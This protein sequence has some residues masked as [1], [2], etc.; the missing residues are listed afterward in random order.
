MSAVFLSNS[1]C[2][3]KQ[4][5]SI[6]SHQKPLKSECQTLNA[7]RKNSA[8]C[9]EIH[10]F[11]PFTVYLSQVYSMGYIRDTVGELM[12]AFLTS[13]AWGTP[14]STCSFVGR[15][16]VT[17][18]QDITVSD[19]GVLITDAKGCVTVVELWASW[20]GPCVKIA[21][22]VEAFHKAHPNVAFISVSADAT[23]GA[24]ESFGDPSPHWTKLSTQ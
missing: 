8:W 20:C 3:S 14:Q 17:E 24:A 2:K 21:P 11:I 10:L 13:L 1:K 4:I 18:R 9:K 12:Y 5:Q 23:A 7:A 6:S 22:E 19:M 15:P 16:I